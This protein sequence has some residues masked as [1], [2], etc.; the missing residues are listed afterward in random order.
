MDSLLL[1]K[2]SWEKFISLSENTL[3]LALMDKKKTLRIK[4]KP[5]DAWKHISC[6]L[7]EELKLCRF[8]KE[9]KKKQPS[10]SAGIGSLESS[11]TVNLINSLIK[12][13]SW[14]MSPNAFSPLPPGPCANEGDNGSATGEVCW[15]YAAGTAGDVYTGW[16]IRHADIKSHLPPAQGRNVWDPANA[17]CSCPGNQPLS[18]GMGEE[19]LT[20]GNLACPFNKGG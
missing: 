20:C 15:G 17:F 12:L 11:Q 13:E 3:F 10:V 2:M 9:K 19:K 18:W 5:T 1:L 16:L 6:G 4:N 8:H 7:I 14:Q